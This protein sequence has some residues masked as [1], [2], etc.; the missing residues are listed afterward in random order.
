M[1]VSPP[2]R[3]KGL[4]WVSLPMLKIRYSLSTN[5]DIDINPQE[6]LAASAITSLHNLS[7]SLHATDSII[8]TTS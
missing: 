5:K 8:S 6:V 1:E 2:S 4:P 3:S 7:S